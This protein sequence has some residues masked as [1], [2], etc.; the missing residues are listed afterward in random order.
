LNDLYGCLINTSWPPELNG[1]GKYVI[2]AHEVPIKMLEAFRRKQYSSIIKEIDKS[3][4]E[5][6]N[7][8]NSDSKK[9]SR[10]CCNRGF[11]HQKLHL[12]RKALKVCSAIIP[13]KKTLVVLSLA[14][15]SLSLF[16]GL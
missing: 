7:S 6:P 1:L 12:N 5:A 10:L 2:A 9:L 11:C 8:G 3:I 15:K 4:R 14:S 13:G 16:A